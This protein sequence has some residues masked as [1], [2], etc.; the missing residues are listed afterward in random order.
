MASRPRLTICCIAS[1]AE[2]TL[3]LAPGADAIG[4]VS[5]MPSGRRVIDD[6]TLAAIVAAVPPSLRT[7]LLTSRTS[8]PAIVA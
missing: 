2:A 1:V 3:A 7:A 4:V 8:A 5:A 6:D